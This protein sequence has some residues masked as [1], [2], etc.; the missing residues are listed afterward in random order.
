MSPSHLFVGIDVA[1][2]HLDLA[3]RPAGRSW[4]VADDG[5]AIAEL[6]EELRTLA[7]TLV[8][9]EATGGAEL[10]LL[11]ALGGAGLP[12]VAINPRQVRDFA[13]ATGRLAKTD[14]LDAE[15]I[16]HF[17]EAVRPAARP[18][19]DARARELH[20]LSA[21]RRQ[22]V[23]ML[24]AERNRLRTASARVAPQL[25]EHIAWLQARL[26]DP[27]ADL[28]AAVR[29]SPLWRE[30]DDLLRGVPGVGP[31][32]SATLLADLPELGELN[33]RD[34]AA[35]VGVAPFN[36]DSGRWRGRRAIWGG[37]ARV[38][39][40]LYMATLVATRHNPAIRAFYLR[41]V[42]AGKPKKVALTAAMRKLLTVLNAILHTR[43]PWTESYSRHSAAAQPQSA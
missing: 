35:L 18:L 25:R 28:A 10:P 5:P 40:T 27:D 36:R 26:R 43:T 31:V 13:R 30:K 33:R 14:R 20:E 6:V 15:V 24:T 34:I 37:R 9:L 29:A 38:R 23:E 3:L 7:P 12:A 16:A 8:V 17:A 22:L 2:D 32:V 41:L 1:K 42:A 4:R 11:A 19:A 39:A 21:R